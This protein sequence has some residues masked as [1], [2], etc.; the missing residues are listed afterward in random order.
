MC[1]GIISRNL[2]IARHAL[3]VQT[4]RNLLERRQRLPGLGEGCKARFRFRQEFEVYLLDP[5]L[6]DAILLLQRLV[7]GDGRHQSWRWEAV[8][9][10]RGGLRGS[11]WGH[12][13]SR[14][15]RCEH[16]G[17]KQGTAAS[18]TTQPGQFRRV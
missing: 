14:R 8:V 7:V 16:L 3:A 17:E 11:L 5:R 2:L 6:A 12:S 1:D 13:R 18:C 15:G 4:S 9:E 10:D